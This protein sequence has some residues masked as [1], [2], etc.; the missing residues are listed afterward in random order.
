M[1]LAT[2][3]AALGDF[4]GAI[5]AGLGEKDMSAVVEPMRRR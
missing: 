4:K 3:A 1:E 2:A 5:A